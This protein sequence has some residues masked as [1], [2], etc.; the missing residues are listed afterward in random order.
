MPWNDPGPQEGVGGVI[1]EDE[2]PRRPG[3]AHHHRPSGQGLHGDGRDHGP[4]ALARSEGV[5]RAQRHHRRLERA[6]IALGQFVSGDLGGGIGRLADQGVG[7]GHGN[8]LGRAID[9]AGR[10]VDQ[11]TDAQFPHGLK[12]VQRAHHVCPDVALRRQIRIGNGDQGAEVEDDL[13]VL[14][15][16]ID[17]VAVGQVAAPH[18]EVGP[19]RRPVQPA[20]V[21]IRG[22]AHQYPDVRAKFDQTFGQAAA[23]EAAGAGNQHA[24]ARIGLQDF[25]CVAHAV[26]S[27]R[28]GRRPLSPP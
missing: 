24:L 4:G 25:R 9:L 28:A 27:P 3:V 19:H 11:T 2:V 10:G 16:V 1:D 22:V 7:L 23:D 14:H 5:E 6:M 17:A 20:C 8:G 26:C 18:V 15:G 13:P 21:P 12:N